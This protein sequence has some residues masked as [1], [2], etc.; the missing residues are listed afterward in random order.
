MR[1]Q[2]SSAYIALAF[3]PP[4]GRGTKGQRRLIRKA[5]LVRDGNRCCWCHEPMKIPSEAG[6][7]YDPD[8]ASIEHIIPRSRGGTDDWDNLALAHLRCNQRRNEEQ[9]A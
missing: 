4:V 9:V 6:D 3:R 5:L 2:E 1:F 7:Q 8:F